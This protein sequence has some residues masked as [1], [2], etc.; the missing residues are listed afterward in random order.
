MLYNE[1]MVLDW[2]GKRQVM[3]RE[4][5][6]MNLRG[7]T[8]CS[9]A[10]SLLELTELGLDFIIPAKKLMGFDPA[11]ERGGLRCEPLV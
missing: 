11:A 5:H 4:D 10:S 8:T 9:A 1:K 3:M 7:A 6:V 2:F